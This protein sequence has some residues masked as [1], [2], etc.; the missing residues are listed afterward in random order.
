M[1]LMTQIPAGSFTSK[2]YTAQHLPYGTYYICVLVDTGNN[3]S[4]GPTSGD[5]MGFY[6]GL[7]SPGTVEVTAAS[8]NADVSSSPVQ[9]VSYDSLPH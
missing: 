8:P 4:S 3:M 5:Y 6:G 9:L 7:Q 2:E 1:V